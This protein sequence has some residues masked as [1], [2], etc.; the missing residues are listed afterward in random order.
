MVELH[1]EELRA[2]AFDA[3]APFYDAY[4]DRFRSDR[5]RESRA[6]VLLGPRSL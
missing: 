4:L 2:A 1:P 5:G 3:I 6:S